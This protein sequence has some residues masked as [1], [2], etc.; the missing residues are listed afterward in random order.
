MKDSMA[1]EKI[2]FFRLEF[3]KQPMP[4]LGTFVEKL[5]EELEKDKE[6]PK[7][8]RRTGQKLFQELQLLG[9]YT[10]L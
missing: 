2:R 10:P 5:T 4:K 8:Q 1:N 7:R 6:L 9:T 3:K